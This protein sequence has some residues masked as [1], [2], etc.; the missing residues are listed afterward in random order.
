[1][2]KRAH[3]R[4]QRN[5]AKYALGALI[6]SVTGGVVGNKTGDYWS[7]EEKEELKKL[8]SQ[9]MTRLKRQPRLYS[10][11]VQIEQLV[12]ASSIM[13]NELEKKQARKTALKLTQT[14]L[15]GLTEHD[16]ILYLKIQKLTDGIY[17]IQ[18][19]SIS[20]GVTLGGVIGLVLAG[21]IK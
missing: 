4:S 18:S 13:K 1:M 3:K 8:T 17:S 5:A 6:G 9:F 7:K 10:L 19:N 15:N 12:K 11:Y 14:F 2:F 21:N 20:V 16:K